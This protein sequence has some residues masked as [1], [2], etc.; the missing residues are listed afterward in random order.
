MARFYRY[1]IDPYA[2][3]VDLDHYDYT[4][5][6]DFVSPVRLEDV[7]AVLYCTHDALSNL[8]DFWQR[9][10]YVIY[11]KDFKKEYFEQIIYDSDYSLSGYDSSTPM[12][13]KELLRIVNTLP[14]DPESIRVFVKVPEESNNA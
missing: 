6:E 9:Y 14:R 11:D 2:V 10:E 12:D 1:Y 5:R 7:S 3:V 4:P 8:S 13:M